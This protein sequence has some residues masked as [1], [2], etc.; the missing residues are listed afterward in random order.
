MGTNENTTQTSK[1]QELFDKI[2]AGL[3]GQDFVQ[4]SRGAPFTWNA[5]MYR[6]E[7]GRK[8]AAGHLIPDEKYDPSFEGVNVLNVKVGAALGFTETRDRVFMGRKD[9][10]AKDNDAGDLEFILR[11]QNAHDD[12]IS[13]ARMKARLRE[14]GEEYGLSIPEV[15]R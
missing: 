14:V 1:K 5:C 2:V 13:P 12:A 9:Q 10:Y 3:A 8:C 11:C 15:L 7:G 4:S 6:G